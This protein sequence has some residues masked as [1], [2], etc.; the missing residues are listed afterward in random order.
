[1]NKAFKHII[2]FHWIFSCCLLSTLGNAQS[3]KTLLKKADKSFAQFKY[4]DA[5]DLYKRYLKAKKEDKYVIYNIAQSYK[6][7]NKYDSA[8]VYYQ[9][10]NDNGINTGNT[11]PELF[12]SIGQY[13]KAIGIY[14]TLNTKRKS[15]LFDQRLLG[16]KN[17]VDYLG[18]SLDFIIQEAKVNTKY[19]EL[20]AVPFNGGFVFESNRKVNK[21]D[22]RKTNTYGWDGGTYSKLYFNNGK[23]SV[24]TLFSNS[25]KGAVNFG[26]ISFTGNGKI[27]Y[28]TRN[29]KWRSKQGVYQLQIWESK[30]EN[31]KWK[32]GKKL[33]INNSNAS[34]FHPAITED[35]KRLYYVSD[36]AEGMGGTDI[37]YIEKNTD[38]TWKPTQN[39]VNEVNTYANELFPTFYNGQLY[40]SSNGHPGL[41]GMDIFRLKKN[42]IGEWVPE[43]LGYPINTDKD[44]FSFYFKDNKGILSSNRKG[45]DDIFSIDFQ[46]AYLDVIGEIQV[47]AGLNSI[48]TIYLSQKDGFGAEKVIDS[49]KVDSAGQYMFKAR[50][51]KNYNLIVRDN[52]GKAHKSELVTN[53]YRLENGKYQQY[54]EVVKVT[55]PIEQV[56]V[57]KEKPE[58]IE[59]VNNPPVRKFAR[60]IDSLATLTNDYTILH[61]LFDRVYVAKDDLKAY[62]KL[63]DRVNNMKGKRVVIV[64]AS[65]C[66]G[67]E[68]YND[69]L[70]KQRAS[71][72]YRAL[73]RN[74]NN[75]VVIKPVGEYELINNCDGSIREQKTNRYSY[76]FIMDK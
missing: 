14:D 43:N 5:I 13:D 59:I 70:S 63:L 69:K 11:I 28:Y 64:S 75:E 8:L 1:M 50:P 2:R 24:A 74:K 19:N 12:A 60:A 71:N 16:F 36:K 41:G 26:S 31:G 67:T 22:R 73:S 49:A 58:V 37:Y 7:L 48:S 34:F 62:F 54:N 9:K 29:A 10:A 65:D 47:D 33:F 53:S 6:N 40:F 46:K 56:I 35:G 51:N 20:A 30:Y 68:K 52:L 61:H 44:D 18:D 39:K 3:S 23:D 15:V 4:I 38:G 57:N 66:K 32:K 25:F 45:T 17:R 27:A 55:K 72:L 42:N 21:K 76:V